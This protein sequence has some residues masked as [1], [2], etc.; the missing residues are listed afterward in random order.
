MGVAPSRWGRAFVCLFLVALFLFSACNAHLLADP[1]RRVCRGESTLSEV[2]RQT[3]AAYVGGI[4][5]KSAFVDLN[6]AYA[7]LIGRRVYHGVSRLN[8]GMLDRDG[9]ALM[10]T[11]ELAASL[12]RLSDALAARG[13]AFLF[14]QVPSKSDL[15]G[16]LTC[17]GVENAANPNADALCA[18]LKSR[19]TEVLDLRP[20]LAASA[21]DVER[22][23]YRTDHH[24]NTDGAFSAFGEV[25][26]HI[27]QMLPARAVDTSWADA[28]RWERRTYP[29]WM[30]GSHGKRVGRFFGGVDDLLLY[31]PRK[32]IETSLALPHKQIFKEGD[33]LDVLVQEAYL[34][35]P[36]YHG[37]DAYCVYL[38]GNY[39]LAVHNTEGVENGAR[40]LLVKDSFSLPLEAML[41]TALSRL[42][43]IDPRYYREESVLEYAER[44]RPDLVV[45][46]INPSVFSDGA[47]L[48]YGA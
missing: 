43:A 18:S 45:V 16:T 47:Y 11:T 42:D 21:T 37:D 9:L 41:S 6:G 23:F 15:A 5:F 20:H 31:T 17:D 25:L 7:R 22:Y 12:V 46:A 33:F 24:W 3:R 39:P 1:L 4:S 34:D 13:I 29:A 48:D 2:A 28:A 40:V 30:L 38:G 27:A 36:D 26:G 8:N 44:T 14:V 10:D 32:R 19:G 35:T